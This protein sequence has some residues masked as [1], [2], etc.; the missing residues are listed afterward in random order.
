MSVF[1]STFGLTFGLTF[2]AASATYSPAYYVFWANAAD[3]PPG[4]EFVPPLV[5]NPVAI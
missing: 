5:A 4:Y 2:G 3:A 1:G